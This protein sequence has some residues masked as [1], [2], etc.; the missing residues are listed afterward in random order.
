MTLEIAFWI[1]PQVG[2][3]PSSSLHA[4]YADTSDT[5]Y[6]DRWVI[7]HLHLPLDQ[8]TFYQNVDAYYMGARATTVYHSQTYT[9]PAAVSVGYTANYRAE[10]RYSS[11]YSGSRNRGTM[12]NYNSR[13]PDIECPTSGAGSRWYV[14]RPRTVGSGLQELMHDFVSFFFSCLFFPSV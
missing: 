11:T 1:G 8:N 5:A 3:A 4:Q 7:F 2:V 6:T 12:A 14:D 13:T 9:R 10:Y